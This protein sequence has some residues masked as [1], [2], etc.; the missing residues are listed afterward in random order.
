M[1]RDPDTGFFRPQGNVDGSVFNDKLGMLMNDAFRE[2][3]ITETGM[4][5]ISE[6]ITMSRS[7][8]TPHMADRNAANVIISNM[9]RELNYTL[10]DEQ[11][12]VLVSE[13]A[14][15]IEGRSPEGVGFT[16]AYEVIENALKG[17]ASMVQVRRDLTLSDAQQPYS[18]D[19]GLVM[20]G[21]LGMTVNSKGVVQILPENKQWFLGE[22]IFSDTLGSMDDTVATHLLDRSRDGDIQQLL[23]IGR[24]AGPDGPIWKKV[25]NKFQLVGKYADDPTAAMAELSKRLD[26]NQQ[27][28]SYEYSEDGDVVAVNINNSVPSG[29]FSPTTFTQSGSRTANFTG[30]DTADALATAA[31]LRE[32]TWFEYFS[33]SVG[34]KEDGTPYDIDSMERQSVFHAHLM[35]GGTDTGRSR[36]NVERWAQSP[37]NRA[38]VADH[39]RPA[40][41]SD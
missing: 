19:I 31:D 25:G 4:A 32:S 27:Y 22:T 13:L 5:A 1:K 30:A 7:I 29:S 6:V 28:V 40:L 14:A 37:S 23:A 8:L 24:K 16:D 17:R 3:G 9:A 33:P 15:A 38:V 35:R 20:G 41:Y 21:A 10:P 2:Q 26:G 18:T 11:R 12:E 39:I 34:F 36:D